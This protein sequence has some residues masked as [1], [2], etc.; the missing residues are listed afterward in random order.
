[1]TW[2]L[3]IPIVSLWQIRSLE[4][5]LK[6]SLKRVCRKYFPVH[7]NLGTYF[8]LTLKTLLLY[9][10]SIKKNK[11]EMWQFPLQVI[12]NFHSQF[13]FCTACIKKIGAW[14]QLSLSVLLLHASFNIRSKLD[15]PAICKNW[16]CIKNCMNK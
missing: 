3:K 12:Q 15:C 16:V 2:N 4:E 6:N 1:M 7:L 14:Y 13:W 10:P 8:F 5:N 11:H 9:Q